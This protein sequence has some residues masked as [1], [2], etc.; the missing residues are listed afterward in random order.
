[1]AIVLIDSLK[2]H[3]ILT[4]KYLSS[5]LSTFTA[6]KIFNII[7]GFQSI[8]ILTLII[9]KVAL[10]HIIDIPIKFPHVDLMYKLFMIF[11]LVEEL[12]NYKWI[13][14]IMDLFALFCPLILIFHKNRSLIISNLVVFLIHSLLFNIS[15]HHHFH[16]IVMYIFAYVPFISYKSEHRQLLWEWF[17]YYGLFIMSSA[18]LWKL[19]RGNCFNPHQFSNILIYQHLELLSRV[20]LSLYGSFIRYFIRHTLLSQWIFLGAIGL[21]LSFILG[22]FTKKYDVLLAYLLLVF[23]VFNWLFMGIPSIFSFIMVLPLITSKLKEFS[24]ERV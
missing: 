22:F 5:F 18:A 10:Y 6:R 3:Y 8:H 11:P 7:L 15:Y 1:M 9:Q 21:E 14:A 16:F 24:S 12:S 19:S 2:F 13:G 20:D 23:L 4:P 17:R